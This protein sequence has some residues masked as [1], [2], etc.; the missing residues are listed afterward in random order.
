MT[1]CARKILPEFNRLVIFS[2]T[3]FSYHG[4]PDPLTCPPGRARISIAQY[5]Y[6]VG[7]PSVER[8]ETHSTVYRKRPDKE[9][10]IDHAWPEEFPIVFNGGSKLS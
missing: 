9:G 10:E 7:R 8:S 1:K 3:D 5:Y 6:S 2:T 4:H